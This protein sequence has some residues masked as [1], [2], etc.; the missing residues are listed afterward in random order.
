[1]PRKRTG[2]LVPFQDAQGKT[3]YRGRVRLAD[4]RREWID[5]PRERA[6]SESRARDYVQWA[7]EQEDA[8]GGLLA[9]RSGQE[10]PS[11]VDG[12]TVEGYAKRWIADRKARALSSV[13]TDEGRLREHVY[14][15]LR[16]IPMAAVSRDK[17][18]DVRDELDRK[19]RHD[20]IKW[21]TAANAWGVISTLFDDACNAKNRELRVLSSNPV[22]GVRPPDRGKKTDKTYLY[23]DEFL[24]LVSCETV[25][26]RWRR[27]FTIAIYL[28]ARAGELN[29]LT[30]E[31]HL[32]L[33][34]GIVRIDETIDRRSGERHD[35]TKT[36][37]ARRL[38]I[39]PNLLPLL[40][41]LLG[42]QAG[43]G[44]VMHCDATDRK[45][46]RQLRR[47]LTIAGVVRASLHKSSRTTKAITFHD[48]RATGIT[49][50]AVRGDDPLR[51]KQR[52]GHTTFATTEGYIREAENLRDVF[53][54][55]FPPLPDALLVRAN[56]R[57][58]YWEERAKRRKSRL[59]TV[60]APGIEG[61]PKTWYST[62]Y[63][64]GI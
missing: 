21:K 55:V 24:Q 44:R 8:K 49:W 28:Y 23:P 4:G 32:D 36:G 29:A 53:G 31:E 13:D 15:H 39:E 63:Y 64:W 48:L 35:S 2:S 18:E 6:Y 56:D 30:L 33:V 60:E 43:K 52:A 9:R 40:N 46:S 1:M 54:T 26:L 50:C 42:E 51:I 41:L 27:V 19:V 59:N 61:G 22:V 58:N 38:P 62:G 57:A 37:L 34:R 12:E 10:L 45:L 5:V 25:P 11:R 14:P 3:Y 17:I 16:T 47:C 20:A 7:Q